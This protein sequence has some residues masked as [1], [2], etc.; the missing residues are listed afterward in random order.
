MELEVD[1]VIEAFLVARALGADHVLAKGNHHGGLQQPL[2]LGQRQTAMGGQ[3]H[4]V[5]HVMGLLPPA[6]SDLSERRSG[7]VNP[8]GLVLDRGLP[9]QPQ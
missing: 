8:L 7:M 5:V 4:R 1:L 2:E 3:E 6:S 9:L